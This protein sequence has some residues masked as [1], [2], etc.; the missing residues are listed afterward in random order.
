[1][2][3]QSLGLLKDEACSD[4]L[5]YVWYDNMEFV[6]KCF[7]RT[8]SFSLIFLSAL[9]LCNMHSAVG[10]YLVRFCILLHILVAYCQLL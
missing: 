9:F 6:R 7:D 4:L 2:F 5:F 3:F 10:V 1:M 8:M